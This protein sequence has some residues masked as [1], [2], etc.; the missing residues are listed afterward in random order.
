MSLVGSRLGR[1][2]IT[3][4][5]GQGGM[6][7]V[8]A[9]KDEDL[10]REVAVKVLGRALD[11]EPHRRRFLREAR[12]AA[13]LNHPNIASIHEVGDSDGRRYIVMELLE[14]RTLRALMNERRLSVDES[15]SIARDVARALARAHSG[16]VT[17]RDV[18]PENIFITTPAPDVLLAK[19]L[20]FGLARDELTRRRSDDEDTAT[21]IAGPGEAC[22][23][24]GYLAP[25]QARGAAV[26]V[27]ADVFSCGAVLYEMLTGKR[28][29]DGK[30]QLARMLAVVKQQHEPLRSRLPDVRPEVEAIVERCLAKEPAER[31]DDG[32]ALLAAL[33]QT[34]R[35]SMRTLPSDVAALAP[36]DEA[37]ES[38]SRSDR[39]V[40]GPPAAPPAGSEASVLPEGAP[41]ALDA[42]GLAS[43]SFSTETPAPSTR[44]ERAPIAGAGVPL[45]RRWPI[46][47][48]AGG[49]LV[50]V[51]LAVA[52]SS[53]RGAMGRAAAPQPQAMLIAS[54]DAADV[55]AK[56]IGSGE[57]ADP[58]ATSDTP[59]DLAPVAS[60][61]VP[62]PPRASARGDRRGAPPARL[63]SA[64]P[65][66]APTGGPT[67]APPRPEA[68]TTGTVRFPSLDVLT[69]VVD[70]EHHRLRDRAVTLP[71]GRHRIR[72][73]LNAERTV[74]VPCGG[75]VSF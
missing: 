28:A 55:A 69:V 34:L 59:A 1:F 29:F 26:D 67:Q 51:S 14:G 35:V 53:W 47:V 31:Y 63:A 41:G 46:L 2:Q 16:D 68:P 10:D 24:A 5:I 45:Q 36:F 7:E 42:G 74:D 50:V 20:D 62:A 71:C 64:A 39:P 65:P 23:T 15:L 49:G 70:G 58:V 6:G 40:T 12:L 22:G 3:R 57:A 8:Y 52:L 25:E 27:R 72:A 60:D 18:K 75:S 13:R 54:D 44:S 19:V 66:G 17:H 21:D 30:N 33:E 61:V 32:S 37:P 73:G 56:V 4:L 9:A 43:R 11:V 38:A 48:A